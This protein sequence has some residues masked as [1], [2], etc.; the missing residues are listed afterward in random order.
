MKLEE[1][2]AVVFANGLRGNIIT[3]YDEGE[4]LALVKCENGNI[5][6]IT[7][8][9]EQNG[10]ARIYCIEKTIFGNKANTDEILNELDEI[11]ARIRE[12]K[13][14]ESQLRKQLWR[15]SQFES[16]KTG[17]NHDATTN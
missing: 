5:E 15:I 9:D 3:T 4:V 14:K 13:K 11:Q 2:Q 12:L 6:Q 10:Y 8:E 17:G 7:V 16:Q 1:R